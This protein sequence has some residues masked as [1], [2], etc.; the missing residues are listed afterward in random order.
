MMRF[1]ICAFGALMMLNFPVIGSAADAGA[2]SPAVKCVTGEF[3]SPK[4][5]GGKGFFSD[6]SPNQKD[7]NNL[8]GTERTLWQKCLKQRSTVKNVLLLPLP[9]LS[10]EGPQRLKVTV[11]ACT[12]DGGAYVFKGAIKQAANFRADLKTYLPRGN[13]EVKKNCPRYL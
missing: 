2:A 10:S 12:L 3:V 4:D 11:F 8:S 9:H 6:V 13:A 7:M 1:V 5:R